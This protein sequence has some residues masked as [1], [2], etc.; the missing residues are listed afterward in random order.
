[1]GLISKWAD[2][3]QRLILENFDT[4]KDSPSKIY[5]EAIPF[6]PSSSWLRKYYSQELLQEV[7]VVKGLQARWGTCSRTVL[8]DSTP[9]SLAC[10]KNLIAAGL[11]FGNIITLD[12]TTGICTSTLAGHT[13][14]VESLAFSLDGTSLASGSLDGDVKLWDIQTGGII[15]TFHCHTHPVLAVSI[16][17][18]Q[19]MVAIGSGDN[20]IRL[21]NT[22]TGECCCTIDGHHS[23]IFSVNFSP[24]DSQLILSA[25]FDRTVRQWST[26]GH[27]IGPTYEGKHATFSSDGTHFVSWLEGVAM[28][29]DS[30]SGIPIATLQAP[31][32]NFGS[33]CFSPNGKF[34][35]GASDNTIYIWDITSSE[36]HLIET[37]VGHTQDIISVAFP[38]SIISSSWDGSIKFWQ[39]DVSSTEPVATDS[40]P[41]LHTSASA[42]IMSISLQAK[43]G[44]AISSD[45]AGVVRTWDIST[46]H[47][48][49]SFHTP[50]GH[51]SWRDA[52]LISGKLI[53]V[54]CTYK[55]IHIWDVEK[56]KH[57]Q[58]IE[59]RS[60]PSTTSPR[61]S[62]DGSKVFLL[63]QESIRA[64][65]IWTG[66]AM[67]EV[68]LGD[69]PIF[70]S[71]T[72]DGSKVCVCFGDSK[73][74][75]WDFGIPG[76]IPIPLSN[77]HPDRPHLDFIH[78]TAI[79]PPRIKDTVTGKEVLQLSRRYERFV[80]VQWDGRY[81]VAGYTS[82]ELL[83]LDFHQVVLQ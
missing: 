2:D 57:I 4:I 63:D 44:I 71:L 56:G 77:S 48:N 25:S 78:G 26:N 45:S 29:R 9:Y 70:D 35:A 8:P 23:G 41:T 1:M 72:V 50:V 5:H 58:K 10:W 81:L 47:C 21:W 59:A 83:I 75:G 61:I 31:I 73:I 65:S 12:A 52:Q 18:D 22:Q 37:L 17:P 24:A 82:G 43:I 33:C 76:L 20:K 13:G 64:W 28:V 80:K 54:W 15:S 49:A 42:S 14:S 68:R 19:T 62:G 40:K 27:Q 7:K 38:S 67:G 55:K 51:K 69:K 53:F 32:G 36:P 30:S 60:R 79:C 34:V 66:E 74:Q 11:K 16:S 46:G 39:I 3:S 6:S